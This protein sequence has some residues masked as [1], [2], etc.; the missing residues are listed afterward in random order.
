MKFYHME[1]LVFR[2]VCYL[3]QTTDTV[4]MSPLGMCLTQHSSLESDRNAAQTDF[5]TGGHTAQ[6]NESTEMWGWA[7]PRAAPSRQGEHRGHLS[8]EGSSTQPPPSEDM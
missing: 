2:V 6:M 7:G 1:P 5:S 3:E 4:W 8:Y